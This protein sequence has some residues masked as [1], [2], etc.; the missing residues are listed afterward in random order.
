[1]LDLEQRTSIHFEISSTVSSSD[2]DLARIKQGLIERMNL[3]NDLELPASISDLTISLGLLGLEDFEAVT[4]PAP[5]WK[6]RITYPLRLFYDR[7]I[8]GPLYIPT[9]PDNPCPH[10]IE[11]RWY[12]NRPKEE[13]ITLRYSPHFISHGHNPFLTPFVLDSIWAAMVKA[14]RHVPTVPTNG[15]YAFYVLNLNTLSLARYHLL[16]DSSCPI[17]ATLTPDTPEAA[18]IALSSCPKPDISTYRLVKAVEYDLPVSGLLNPLCGVLGPDVY[19]DLKN[20]LSAPMTGVFHVRS[21][22]ASH[23][24]WW[25]GHGNRYHQSL[26]LGFLEGIERY[27]GHSSHGKGIAVTDCYENLGSDALDPRECGVYEEI[28]YR[29]K[30]P[31]YVPFTPQLKIPWVWGYSFRQA[32][33]ILVPE[34]LVYYLDYH[35][36]RPAFVQECSNGCAVGSNLEEAIFHGLL[37]LI[38]RDAFMLTWYARLS[39]PKIDPRSCSSPET[40][41][42]LEGIEKLGYDLYLFDMR[43]DIPIPS[44]LGVAK[45]RT[46]GLGNICLAAGAGFEPEDA[47]RGALCEIACF[48][49]DFSQRVEKNLQAA[50]EMMQDFS[51]I[52]E[53]KHHS[54]LHGLPE[55]EVHD[56]FLFQNPV[57]RSLEESYRDWEDMRPHNQD[58]RDDVLF[59]IEKIMQLGMDVIVVDQTCPEQ[60]RSGLCTVCVIV[61]GLLPVDFGWHKARVGR[62]PRLRTVPRAMGY[63]ETD[64]ELH[65]EDIIPHPFP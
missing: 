21:R 35:I 34:Q 56:R 54:L 45:L 6:G 49:P 47:V 64:F 33:P 60:S 25:S 16:Q 62:L 8:L 11:R 61:P 1:M 63:R 40:L 19:A 36:D 14:L 37:E 13:Q 17:C 4:Q 9:W 27:A 32:R 41:F 59:C 65:M 53:L 52:Q 55:M 51:K 29:E 15:E 42:V 10:C 18:T 38:E 28:L 46:P 20:T 43:L 5:A 23:E 2:E 12:S 48:V 30:F 50:R 22:F 24:A 7:L 3:W 57:C 39:P 58:L 44:I 31:L 26:Y